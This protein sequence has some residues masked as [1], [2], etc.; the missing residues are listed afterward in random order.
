MIKKITK[1]LSKKYTGSLIIFTGLKSQSVYVQHLQERD[2]RFTL[3]ITSLRILKS[4]K[5][6]SFINEISIKSDKQLNVY[7]FS[8]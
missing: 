6:Q 3:Q 2:L 1:F 7:Q 8:K 5:S 4:Y